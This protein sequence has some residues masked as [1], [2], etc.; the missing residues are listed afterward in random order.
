MDIRLNN[1]D[2]SITSRQM[3]E[4]FEGIKNCKEENLQKENDFCK[5]SGNT[6]G[7]TKASK[8]IS[9]SPT[10]MDSENEETNL[11]FERINSDSS[12]SR[13]F[14]SVNNKSQ[15]YINPDPNRQHLSNVRNQPK[16]WC[17]KFFI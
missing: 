7:K 17:L 15:I 9:S 14:S 10:K 8:R 2:N 5:N 13:T 16:D 1:H 6:A 4:K 3:S 12:N 11:E